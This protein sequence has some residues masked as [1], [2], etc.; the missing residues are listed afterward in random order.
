MVR[1]RHLPH[2]VWAD[3]VEEADA[4]QAVIESAPFAIARPALW[5]KYIKNRIKYSKFW[6][7]IV[8]IQYC[9]VVKIEIIYLCCVKKYRYSLKSP[10]WGSSNEHPQDKF[11]CKIYTELLYLPNVRGQAGLHK[12]C[13]L[14]WECSIWSG[15]TLFA[16]YPGPSCSKL[17]MS[18]VNVS[19][20]LWSLNMAYTLIFLHLQKLL[21]FFQQKYLWIRY[22][23]Y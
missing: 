22:C 12:Q 21:T 1:I 11:Q 18:L 2:H 4:T 19:L 15:C 14:R 20:K 3:S 10:Q 16:T 13:R 17:T 5:N 9:H 6:D 23:T 7:F 8:L